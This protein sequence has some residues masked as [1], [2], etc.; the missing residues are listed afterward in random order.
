MLTRTH[1]S[2]QGVPDCSYCKG[3]RNTYNGIEE[4]LMYHKVGFSSTKL[5][6]DDFEHLINRNFSRSGTYIY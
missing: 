3:I 4:N 6:A 2:D 1:G 5:R